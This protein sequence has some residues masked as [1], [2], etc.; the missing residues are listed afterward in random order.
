MNRNFIII[1]QFIVLT[2]SCN[3]KQ[4]DSKNLENC[5]FEF[6]INQT[7]SIA[8]KYNSETRR[9]SKLID[10]FKDKPLYAD[11]MV[12]ISKKQLCELMKLYSEYKIFDYP[13]Q[14]IPESRNKV[15]P[16]PAYQL[17]FT[18]QGKKKSINWKL[19]TAM[20]STKEAANLNKIIK[21]IDSLILS[22]PE[23][24]ALP[25]RQYQWL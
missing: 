6:E 3:S 2:I 12:Q 21:T 23:F 5:S 10:P 15:I 14:F 16:E 25:K 1:I 19:N 22:T 17:N 20:Y 13:D 9:L 7:S 24:K 11:T 18:Y 8:Y 4:T